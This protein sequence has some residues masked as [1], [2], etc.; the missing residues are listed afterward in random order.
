M[1]LERVRRLLFFIFIWVNIFHWCEVRV[2]FY[3][4]I[5]LL[6]LGC[7]WVNCLVYKSHHMS[8]YFCNWKVHQ[9]QIVMNGNVLTFREK[10]EEPSIIILIKMIMQNNELVQFSLFW[11]TSVRS[12][13]FGLIRSILVYL[14]QFGP[15]LSII[16]YS[17]HFSTNSSTSVHLVHSVCFG[18]LS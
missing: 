17:A 13:K 1:C 18:P 3:F 6:V 14:G 8:R 15:F 9:H 4:S 2:H 5:H 7:G 12:I 11:S 16:I 10:I